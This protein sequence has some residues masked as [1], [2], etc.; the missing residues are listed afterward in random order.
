MKL[1]WLPAARD[2]IQRLYDFLIERD[3]AAALRMLDRIRAGA[4][5]LLEF[6]R[7]GKR[8]D[9]DTDRRELYVPFGVGAYVLRYRLTGEALVV[10]RVWHSRESRE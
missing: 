1:V 3:P 5:T 7:A 6:P 10:I 4:A 2:D 8:M 9:N